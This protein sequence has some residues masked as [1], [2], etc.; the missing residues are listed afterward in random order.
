M[1][2]NIFLFLAGLVLLIIGADRFIHYLK[3]LA[4]KLN[5]NEFIIGLFLASF[6]T[7][8][9]EITVSIISSIQ[10]N[11]TIALENALGSVLVNIAFILG[12]SSILILK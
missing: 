7:T 4:K 10:G 9:P 6:A 12:I 3:L 5:I 11:S 2:V 1:F 8:L